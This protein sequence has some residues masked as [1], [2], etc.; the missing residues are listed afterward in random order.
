MSH[1]HRLALCVLFS[2]SQAAV[3]PVTPPDLYLALK[4]CEKNKNVGV[5]RD[6]GL[7]HRTPCGVQVMVCVFASTPWGQ[8]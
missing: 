1:K 4:K 7:C 8:S 3:N 5:P 2:A 6:L